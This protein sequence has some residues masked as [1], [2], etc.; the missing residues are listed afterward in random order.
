MRRS[1]PRRFTGHS[2][3]QRSQRRSSEIDAVTK[4]IRRT[5]VKRWELVG[6]VPGEGGTFTMKYSLRMR[7]AVRGELLDA[8]RTTPQT[9]GVEL[10]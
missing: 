3:K 7:R 4:W 10:R 8:V 5:R 1:L 9:I 6:I 2:V